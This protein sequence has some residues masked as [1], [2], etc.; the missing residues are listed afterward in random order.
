MIFEDI[1]ICHNNNSKHNNINCVHILHQL[2]MLSLKKDNRA[3]KN[4]F[5]AGF[6]K[7]IA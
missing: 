6:E 4:L 3:V 5:W 2:K 7:F 1:G